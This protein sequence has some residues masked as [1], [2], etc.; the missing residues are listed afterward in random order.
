MFGVVRLAEG[1][2]PESNIL[3]IV[4]NYVT[5][6]MSRDTSGAPKTQEKFLHRS[7]GIMGEYPWKCSGTFGYLAIAALR[8]VASQKAVA[9]ANGRLS[10]Q[11]C[12]VRFCG[13]S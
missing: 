1:D 5:G 12:C 2:E 6:A 13:L 8:T 4:E 10:A 9:V 11:S 7:V 3:R